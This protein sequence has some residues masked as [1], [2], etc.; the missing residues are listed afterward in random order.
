MWQVATLL[1]NGELQE[2]KVVLYFTDKKTEAIRTLAKDHR[3]Y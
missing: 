3:V 1:D 2:L